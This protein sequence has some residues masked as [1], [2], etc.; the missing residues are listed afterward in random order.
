MIKFND[1]GYGK[2]FIGTASEINTIHETKACQ[3]EYNQFK[4]SLSETYQENAKSYHRPGRT[5]ARSNDDGFLCITYNT[6]HKT[7]Q[8]KKEPLN[9]K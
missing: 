3:D 1:P 6:A 9:H 5:S 2:G 4:Q 8:N 7:P